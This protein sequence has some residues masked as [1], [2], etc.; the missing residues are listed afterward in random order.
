[1]ASKRARTELKGKWVDLPVDLLAYTLSFLSVREH[2]LALGINKHWGVVG[3]RPGSWCPSAA[4]DRSSSLAYLV[5]KNFV[6]PKRLSLNFYAPETDYII[7]GEL[8]ASFPEEWKPS[9]EVLEL[10]D[11]AWGMVLPGLPGTLNNLR[12]LEVP[13]TTGMRVP[14][15]CLPPNLKRL[16]GGFWSLLWCDADYEIHHNGLGWPTALTHVDVSSCRPYIAFCQCPDL[17]ELIYRDRYDVQTHFPAFNWT[18]TKLRRLV[19]GRREMRGDAFQAQWMP[20]LQQ[21]ADSIEELQLVDIEPGNHILA[22]ARSLILF[23]FSIHTDDKSALTPLGIRTPNLSTAWINAGAFAAAANLVEFT[24]STIKSMKGPHRT[25]IFY[26]ISGGM[27]PVVKQQTERQLL[28]SEDNV[29]QQ[30]SVTI[31]AALDLKGF[32]V[33]K[34]DKNRRVL[35][36]LWTC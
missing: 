23:F 25:I 26:R 30:S 15:G 21:N 19:M 35:I 18:T 8:H 34:S 32:E 17:E 33:I 11:S 4:L 5:R 29:V 16:R 31:A 3:T 28:V 12:E 13:F 24:I 1:M 20:L 27:D 9:L 36:V 6:R 2:C 10:R 14:K 22:L 7:W